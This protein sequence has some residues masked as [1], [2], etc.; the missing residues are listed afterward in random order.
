MLSGLQ[1]LADI[2]RAAGIDADGDWAERA[3]QHG[4]DAGRDR[5]LAQPGGIEMHVN[6]DRAWRGDHALAVT[7]RRRCR[8]NQPRI[9]TVHD[10]GIAG[11]AE[12]DDAAV[13]DAQITFD[14]ADDRINDQDIA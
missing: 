12:A 2:K 6:V 8:Y 13:L 4:G 5:V 7:D 10:R 11:L 3:A 1:H 9:D 14:D